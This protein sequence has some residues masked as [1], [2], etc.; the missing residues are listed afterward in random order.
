MR[1]FEM[2]L[3]KKT[4]FWCDIALNIRW[5]HHTIDAYVKCAWLTYTVTN[6]SSITLSLIIWLLSSASSS[7]SIFPFELEKTAIKCWWHWIS[8]AMCVSF[9][10]SSSANTQKFKHWYWGLCV[11]AAIYVWCREMTHHTRAV[12]SG[13]LYHGDELIEFNVVLLLLVLSNRAKVNRFNGSLSFFLF[14]RNK[15]FTL[16]C[17][18]QLIMLGK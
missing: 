11:R 7:S 10:L 12:K 2:Q 1:R 6:T 15:H 13:R 14:A 5:P 16:R 8:Q 9:I 4:G 18:E 17:V 3:T